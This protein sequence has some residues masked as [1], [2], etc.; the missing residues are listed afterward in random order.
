MFDLSRR[1][2][3]LFLR[4]IPQDR[5]RNSVPSAWGSFLFSL[6]VFFNSLIAR[7]SMHSIFFI[8][9]AHR[10]S[11]LHGKRNLPLQRDFQNWSGF[12]TWMTPVCLHS[13]LFSPP[14]KPLQLASL[15]GSHFFTNVP[16][17]EFPSTLNLLFWPRLQLSITVLVLFPG[18][19]QLLFWFAAPGQHARL[20]VSTWSPQLQFV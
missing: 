14:M 13:F 20:H 1:P 4:S 3:D 8:H 15:P 16:L 2:R 11:G 7:S 17:G 18:R 12:F 9:H 6:S 19:I 5:F 10:S